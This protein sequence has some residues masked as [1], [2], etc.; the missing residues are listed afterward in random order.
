[1][2]IFL[3]TLALANPFTDDI[4]D[5]IAPG[6]RK[7]ISLS[8]ALTE[9]IFKLDLDSKLIGVSDFSDYPV[10]AK[11]KTSVGPY[12][13]PHLEKIASLN[14]DL[15]L[16]PIEGPDEIKD[17]LKRLNIPFATIKMETLDDVGR[18]ALNLGKW[19]G[20]A[21]AGSRFQKNWNEELGK[22]FQ[23]TTNSMSK[24]SVII[25][26][27]NSPL[28]VAGGKT[29]LD[30]I[31]NKCG[32]NN[33][34]EKQTGYPKISQEF[35]TIKKAD[36]VLLADHFETDSEKRKAISSWSMKVK[37]L[38]PDLVARPGP[39]LLNGAREICSAIRDFKNA[40]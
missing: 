1:M 37:E 32:G 23:N 35:L 34:F 33:V 4:G 30:E 39:R 36:L 25:E 11:Q 31:V 8:P 10:G 12:T 13:K 19:L 2:V 6:A 15:V 20:K 27:Q 28:I 7:I 3:L 38:D 26:I 22:L 18:T 5:V 29:F 16:L 40:K 14:P 21:E 24:P 17:Q 9:I